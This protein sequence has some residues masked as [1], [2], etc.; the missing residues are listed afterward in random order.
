V[1]LFT[2]DVTAILAWHAALFAVALGLLFLALKRESGVRPALF[3]TVLAASSPY[4]FFYARLAW[5]N[6][7]QVPETALLVWLIA[8]LQRGEPVRPWRA[9]LI[10]LTCG[11]LFT[12]HL[13]SAPVVGASALLFVGWS[14]WRARLAAVALYAAGFA[15]VAAVY[16][17]KVIAPVHGARPV[18]SGAAAAAGQ[19]LLWSWRFLSS[20]GM[21]YFFE[22]NLPFRWTRFDPAWVLAA[23][24]A[25]ALLWTAWSF[26][27]RSP[28]Q[29]F[30]LFSFV[31]VLNLAF[32]VQAARVGARDGGTRGI[33]YGT[34]QQETRRAVHD[35]CTLAA[36]R[37]VPLRLT[38]ETPG[39]F[40]VAVDWL[41]RHDPACRA[42]PRAGS[43]RFAVRLHY[44][45]GSSTDAHLS[46]EAR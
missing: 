22:G 30:A 17:I 25:A 42:L 16:V 36:A 34:A 2:A 6:T 3:A 32:V 37:Q 12:T 35:A 11:L 29:R 44:P 27:Q 43:E 8:G 18:L 26:R 7:F 13:M 41:T 45:T 14:H 9:G 20:R 19:T 28:L 5:D 38:L 10:G 21:D 15:A 24:A 1:R 31:M 23:A 33:H 40:Q 4:L 46:V 39:V